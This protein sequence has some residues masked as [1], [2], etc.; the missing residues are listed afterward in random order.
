ML[1]LWTLIDEV[2]TVML[3]MFLLMLTTFMLIHEVFVD[4]LVEIWEMFLLM[5]LVLWLMLTAFVLM[6]EVFV[7]ML[8]EI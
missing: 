5:L 6:H 1:T 8:V 3:C 7:D 4:M 2:L